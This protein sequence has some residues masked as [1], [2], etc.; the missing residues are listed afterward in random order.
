MDIRRITPEYAVAPQI[1]PTDMAT[2]AAEGFRTVINNRP[3]SEVPPELQSDTMRAAAEAA[4]L[5]YVENPVVNGAMTMDMVIGQGA[6][7]EASEGP[8]FAYCRSGTR[9]SIVW[10]LSQAGT[11]PTDDLLK[12][13]QDAGYDLGGLRGQIDALSKG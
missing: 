8:V 7:I 10:A 13:A 11:Q 1:E 2:L 5:D 3:D 6:A 9:S 12:A 4:G